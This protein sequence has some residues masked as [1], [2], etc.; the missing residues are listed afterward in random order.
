MPA[1]LRRFRRL[2]ALLLSCLLAAPAGAAPL[3]ALTARYALIAHGL[4][5]ARAEL[6]SRPSAAGYELHA[7]VEG[8]GLTGLF[9]EL[10]RA[11]LTGAE[12]PGEAGSRP[13]SFIV[14]SQPPFTSATTLLYDWPAGRLHARHGDA[15]SELALE[16]GLVDPLAFFAQL[17]EAR[18]SGR[19]APQRLRVPYAS[20]IVEY[21][22]DALGRETL[23]TV[24]GARDTEKYELSR[25]DGG[26]GRV[27]I[28]LWL[29]PADD[30]LPVLAVRSRKHK[31]RARAELE[32][33]TRP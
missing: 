31:E 22:L 24:L 14:H 23:P 10:G 27:R 29:S 7:R 28:T 17:L 30:W 13:L 12:M 6:Q 33:V 11:G 16:A 26:A 3:P 19:P 18:R 9:G 25:A 1:S 21:R 4:T 8:G 5:V 15:A 20:G 2:G 32:A